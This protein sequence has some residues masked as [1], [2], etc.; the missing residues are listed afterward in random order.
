MKRIRFRKGSWVILPA[1][2]FAWFY[3]TPY[4]VK[5][6]DSGYP[7][8]LQWEAVTYG[9]GTF[10]AV[11]SSGSGNRVMTSTDGD[12]WVSQNSASDSNWQGITYA[13]GQFV[14]V[15]SNAVMTSPDGI[16]WTSK[17]VPT[18][19]WQ[20]ITNC[21]G[22][23]VATATW[24]SGYV[25]TSTDGSEWTLRTPAYGWSHDAVACSAEVPRFVSVSQYGRAW[26]SAVG[27]TN[28]TIQNPGAIV[29]IR[30]VAFGNGRFTWLEY[31]T[32]SGNRY[33]GYSTN[34]V[35]WS[36]GLVPS[37]QWKYITY[38]GDKFVAV[39]EGGLNSRVAYSSDG[40]NWT[41]GSGAPI[42]SW[43]GVA[44]GNGKYVAVANSGTDNRVMTSSDGIAWGELATVTTTTTT[45]TEPP[46]TTTTVAPYLNAVT[47]LTAVANADGSVD[48]DWDAPTSSN[49]DI[50][51]YGVLFY[52]LTAIGGTTSGGWGVW[53]NQGT[54]YSLSTGM[55]SGS[56]PVT[57]GYGPV[58]FGIKAGNQSC[59][60]NQGVGSCVYGPELTVDATVLDPTPVT[61]TTSST[62]TTTT[63]TTVV[64][65]N[66]PE[67]PTTTIEVISSPGTIP[68]APVEVFPQPT[69][70][71]I[72][73]PEPVIIE[74]PAETTSSIP[75]EVDPNTIL[76]DPNTAI[77]PDE[78]LPFV[79]NLEPNL[80]PD[81]T[82]P[83]PGEQISNN[84][85]NNILD[86][87]FTSDAS[88]EEMGAVL[89]GLLDTE[90]TGKQFDAVIDATLGSLDEPGSDVGAVLDSFL[91]ADL[92]EKEFTKVLDAVF[93]ADISDEVFAEALTTMLDA[94]LS[95]A[96]FTKVLDAAFS[97][98]A[99]AETMIAAL[100][101]VFDGP[102]SGADI[103]KVMGAVFDEDISAE[104]TM[105]VLGDLLE[106][107][108]SLSEAEA[109]F[110]NV[111]DADLSDA[112]TIDLIVDVLKD[113]LTAE[114][115]GAALGAVF[116]EEVSTEVLVETFT[117]VLG[118]E[119]DAESVGVIVD[120]LESESITNDQVS[121]V[122][123][124]IV[125]QDGGV[126]ADQ[127]TE[128]AT[129]PKVLESID[130]SQA[131]EVFDVIVVSEV[132]AEDGLAISQALVDAPTEV[133]EAFEEELNIF[134]GVFDIYVPTDSG[135]NVGVR[136]TFV[137]VTAIATTLTMTSGAAPLSGGS[138]GGSGGSPAGGG[139]MPDNGKSS[140]INR[141]KGQPRRR[142]K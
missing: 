127:A 51:A 30:T 122:V 73:D 3:P 87:T 66:T 86:N 42:N 4:S 50:Y 89:D 52:D 70:D 99:S 128:L 78:T 88:A 57:T 43:Q 102:A 71:V 111:F 37:N 139:G 77:G 109:V 142:I 98:T 41:L 31:S 32:N 118:N 79:P 15:G 59:F 107:N 103:S 33:G 19:E 126:S 61:T 116:D 40:A 69:P 11:A 121:Q 68:E 80:E 75:E 81:V 125:N 56:N 36:A 21:G 26:S 72:L 101:S 132:T 130:G 22:L 106:T 29:D 2:I 110:D 95:D 45:T 8:D 92:S 140:K 1:L 119:L 63:T 34:G 20:A 84:E 23:F 67:A 117:A 120:V 134:E 105:T 46:T 35:N 38:G 58:R 124:L 91:G 7:A 83:L 64:V 112:E 135:I 55:F 14:A 136:R 129:S 115:L 27:I 44:Y 62:T 133:K 131:T 49:V 90:L 141:R 17:S 12:S 54:N 113:G 85:L 97:E 104:D 18:G 114:N 39:A 48:L 65:I 25:M 9:N 47:N 10:V 123:D 28:W 60:S 24:G 74:I 6:I 93:S 138:S 137:A 16:Q 82:I 53:T 108:L 13:D 5:A 96:E 76:P 94:D 100:S